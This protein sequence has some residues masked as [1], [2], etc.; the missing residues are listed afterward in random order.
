M[1]R[2][3]RAS[4]VRINQVGWL[5]G[6]EEIECITIFVCGVSIMNLRL[7][8]DSILSRDLEWLVDRLVA[9]LRSPIM[10][11]DSDIRWVNE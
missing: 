3:T 2:N 10:I 11:L 4:R 1:I 9:I 7:E 5:M 6:N 8:D